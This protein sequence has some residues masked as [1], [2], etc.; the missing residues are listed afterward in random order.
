MLWVVALE[1]PL[2][3][4]VNGPV[5]LL[6]VAVSWIVVAFT[7]HAAE[8]IATVGLGFTTRVPEQLVVQPL[9]SVIVTL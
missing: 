8:L 6:G 1:S 2:H 9:E 5:P 7:L 4:N 3:W